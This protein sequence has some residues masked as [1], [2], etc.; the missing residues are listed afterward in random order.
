[1]LSKWRSK[2]S[3]LINVSENWSKYSKLLKE[4]FP[5]LTDNDLKLDRGKENEL[6]SK[7]GFRLNKRRPEVIAIIKNIQT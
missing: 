7:L 5:T 2:S 4:R 3:E 1:M 6:F